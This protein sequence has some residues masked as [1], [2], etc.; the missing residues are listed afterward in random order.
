MSAR[1]ARRRTLSAQGRLPG[2]QTNPVARAAA[3]HAL[4]TPALAPLALRSFAAQPAPL[5]PVLAVKAAPAL[6]LMAAPE[7]PRKAT[8]PQW[9]SA[10]HNLSANAAGELRFSVRGTD[11]RNTGMVA[12]TRVAVADTNML[13]QAK[14]ISG[15]PYNQLRRKVIDKMLAEGGWI[16]NDMA[17]ELGG[18]RT[19]IVVAESAQADGAHTGWV[20]YFTEFNGQVY[21]LTTSARVNHAAALA[22]DAEHF[23]AALNTHAALAASA[24]H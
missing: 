9:P 16:V 3:A 15:V 17:R 8:A 1:L 4:L 21:G 23:V 10:W 22:A 2:A 20:F 13:P 7:P 14:S 12:W 19:F 6:P 5:M 18:R 24:Q 11:E